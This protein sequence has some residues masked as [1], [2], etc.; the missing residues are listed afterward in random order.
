MINNCLE[1]IYLIIIK[2]TNKMLTILDIAIIRRIFESIDPYEI[3]PVQID[4]DTNIFW[5]EGPLRVKRPD[6]GP[7]RILGIIQQNILNFTGL[8]EDYTES[9]YY[10]AQESCQRN[11]NDEYNL[12]RIIYYTEWIFTHSLMHS[13]DP[14]LNSICLNIHR[15]LWSGFNYHT[16]S[17]GNYPENESDFEDVPEV[18]GQYYNSYIEPDVLEHMFHYIKLSIRNIFLYCSRSDAVI[19]LLIQRGHLDQIVDNIFRTTFVDTIGDETQTSENVLLL[20][21]KIFEV[22]GMSPLQYHE[23]LVASV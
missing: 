21:Q 3:S 20:F 13:T 10:G 2:K 22:D 19:S 15:L 11:A 18:Y 14:Y 1:I 17:M 4:S 6:W 5:R 9:D 8:V 7:E 16:S 12:M 23:S